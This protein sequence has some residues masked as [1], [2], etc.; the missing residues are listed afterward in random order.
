[1]VN[2]INR[3]FEMA[4]RDFRMN[5]DEPVV[6]ID[7]PAHS[8]NLKNR[9]DMFVEVAFCASSSCAV[10]TE[11]KSEESESNGWVEYDIMHRIKYL[12]P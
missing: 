7:A 6:I 8:G 3:R 1:M 11:E 2:E 10:R 9:G 5:T 4:R 12:N